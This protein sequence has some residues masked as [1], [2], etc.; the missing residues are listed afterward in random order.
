MVPDGSESNYVCTAGKD[1]CGHSLFKSLAL[2]GVDEDNVVRPYQTD[3]VKSS[4]LENGDYC[5]Y[6]FS[7]LGYKQG[8]YFDSADQRVGK[9]WS[10]ED[11]VGRDN[12]TFGF[13]FSNLE[14]VEVKFA[15]LTDEGYE[16]IDVEADKTYYIDV[17][18]AYLE[19]KCTGD[20]PSYA[21]TYGDM[22]EPK[23]LAK[24]LFAKMKSA[25]ASKLRGIVAISS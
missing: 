22:A 4:K 7:D 20:V 6:D 24:P 12:R 8:N 19:V 16:K 9:G 11:L 25:F 1:K 21:F 3:V 5:E 14:D 18:N 13:R 2:V 23:P 10:F 17:D 15:K